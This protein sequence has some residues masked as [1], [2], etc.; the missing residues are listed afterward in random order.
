VIAQY[1]YLYFS[2]EPSSSP[3]HSLRLLVD[4]DLF[5]ADIVV[6]T[7]TVDVY[8]LSPILWVPLDLLDDIVIGLYRLLGTGLPLLLV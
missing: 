7:L 2:N 5:V 1:A 3:L 8:V 4:G 6:S